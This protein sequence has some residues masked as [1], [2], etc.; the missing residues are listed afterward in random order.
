MARHQQHMDAICTALG[1]HRDQ[2]LA[3]MPE[4]MDA[5]LRT[6]LQQAAGS[7]SGPGGSGGGSSGQPAPPPAAFQQPPQHAAGGATI[8][9]LGSAEH[10]KGSGAQ[11]ARWVVQVGLVVGSTIPAA[12]IGGNEAAAAAHAA[13][14]A[15]A[16]ACRV[17][18]IQDGR[19]AALG[20]AM[21]LALSR[22]EA[23]WR[24]AR[25]R[26][27]WRCLQ[28]ASITHACAMQRDVCGAI[29]LTALAHALPTTRGLGA[30]RPEAGRPH[31]RQ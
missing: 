25:S 31:T 28:Q 26:L 11:A 18:S 1:F 15:A 23:G 27:A 8:V 20:R 22:G 24:M 4:C 21:T 13:G 19:P 17:L 16:A 2:G 12:G 14:D 10:A 3:W 7:G 5:Y 9:A 30:L 6:A 29:T